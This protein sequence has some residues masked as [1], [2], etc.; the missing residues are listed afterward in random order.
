MI[1]EP[2]SESEDVAKAIGDGVKTLAEAFGKLEAAMMAQA[3][4]ETPA[5]VVHVAPAKNEVKVNVPE[6]KFPQQPVLSAQASKPQQPVR[7]GFEIVRDRD[8]KITSLFA[9]PLKE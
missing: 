9:N 3:K 5:P 8:G 6:I 4:K 7:W 2:I 1:E